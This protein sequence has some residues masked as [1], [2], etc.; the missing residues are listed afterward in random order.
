MGRKK[1]PSMNMPPP[2]VPMTAEDKAKIDGMSHEEMLRLI[3]FSPPG[4]PLFVGET[5]EY[6]LKL[7]TERRNAL[8]EGQHAATSKSIGWKQ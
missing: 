3:R 4:Y 8:P 1:Q 5:G 7:F 2:P 6:F